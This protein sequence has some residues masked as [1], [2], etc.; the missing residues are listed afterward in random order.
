MIKMSMAR[1]CHGQSPNLDLLPPTIRPS[2]RIG[3]TPQSKN[4]EVI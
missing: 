4:K 1:T 3:R 2:P